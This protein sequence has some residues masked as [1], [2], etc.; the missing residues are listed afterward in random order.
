M[1]GSAADAEALRNG[2]ASA[3]PA[4]VMETMAGYTAF[5]GSMDAR[6]QA[7]TYFDNTTKKTEQIGF[8]L[9]EAVWRTNHGYDPVIRSHF[10]WSQA[11]SS[12]SMERYEILH[13]SFLDLEAAGTKIGLAQ[14]VNIT[15]VV[16]D[17]GHATPYACQDT[18]TGSNVLSVA[19]DPANLVMAAAWERNTGTTWRP[20]CC[21]T[22]LQLDMKRWF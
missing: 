6:E 4:L 22:Y 12:W 19:Y 13:Q 21:S 8:P 11:P 16:G 3:H 18:P 20:A 10:E 9:P 7:A 15:A 14:A 2:D 5:F 17:K 1:V